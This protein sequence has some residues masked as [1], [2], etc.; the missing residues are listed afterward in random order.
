MIHDKTIIN[1]S[2]DSSVKNIFYP[3]KLTCE[4]ILSNQINV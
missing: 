3:I 4:P 1:A 2:L